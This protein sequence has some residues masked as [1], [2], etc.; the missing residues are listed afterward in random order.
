MSPA[1]AKVTSSKVAGDLSSIIKEYY[2]NHLDLMMDLGVGA[3][4]EY[5]VRGPMIEDEERIVFYLKKVTDQRLELGMGNCPET[6][7]LILYFTEQALRELISSSPSAKTYYENY[8]KIMKEGSG[9][10]D[11]D[12]KINKSWMNLVKLGYRNWADR[13]GFMNQT[14]G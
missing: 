11:L 2:P 5:H 7:D 3:V 12:Y 6:P 10:R 9:T 13:Y 1:K 8:S 4:W 14:G